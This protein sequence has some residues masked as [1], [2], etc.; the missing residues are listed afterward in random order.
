M[1]FKSAPLIVKHYKS[2]R[3]SGYLVQLSVNNEYTDINQIII[4]HRIYLVAF[5]NRKPL[6]IHKLTQ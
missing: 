6:Y 2:V 4:R 3:P 1:W 5:R